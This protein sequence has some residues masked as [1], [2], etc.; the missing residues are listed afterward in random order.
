MVL[1]GSLVVTLFG[2]GAGGMLILGPMIS[3]KE[4]AAADSTAPDDHG[5]SGDGH[6]KEGAGTPGGAMHTIDNM[7][8]NPAMSNGSRFL[9]VATAVECSDGAI[10]EELKARDAEVRDVLI[11]VMGTRTV[12]QL[13]DLAQRDS[14]RSEIATAINT[15]LGKP[16]AVRRVYFSQFVVQ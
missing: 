6:G 15:M 12:E 8:L 13:T 9:L 1:I 16:E 14:L 2:G 5:E 7:V 11:N 3:G 4:A 10:V